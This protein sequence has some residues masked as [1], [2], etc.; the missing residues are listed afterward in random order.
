[1]SQPHALAW[2]LSQALDGDLNLA[3]CEPFLC[4]SREGIVCPMRVLA[5]AVSQ[6]YTTSAFD[7]LSWLQ[8]G[9]F[10]TAAGV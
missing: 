6:M 10:S 5:D 4:C 3:R 7:G 8:A 2:G 1:M 9:Q